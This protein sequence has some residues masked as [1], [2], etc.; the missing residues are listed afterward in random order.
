MKLN[1]LTIA[2]VGFAGFAG[3]YAYRRAHPQHDPNVSP[4]D[5]GVFAQASAQRQESGAAIQQNLDY[6][7]YWAS[8]LSDT[9]Y[10]TGSLGD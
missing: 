8:P 6:L 1:L 5:T 7:R 9:I 4:D 10:S 2:A 3:L